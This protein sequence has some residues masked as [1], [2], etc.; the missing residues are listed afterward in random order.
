[1][2]TINTDLGSN[3]E[4]LLQANELCMHKAIGEVAAERL[5]A[6]IRYHLESGG[7]R[8]RAKIALNAGIAL[9]LH[10]DICLALATSCELIHNAS[11]LHDDIQ[12]G[13]EMRRGRES[14]WF[15]YDVN[16]A[17]CAGTLML[18]AA[19]RA[20]SQVP[21]YA[22]QLLAH[23]YQRTSDLISGQTI[24]LTSQ[25]QH[26]DVQTYLNI[27]KGKSGS[28]LALPFELVMISANQTAAIPT[29]KAAGESFAVAYQIAD[30]ISD[31]QGDLS[32]HQNNIIK[33]LHD[34]GLDRPHALAKANQLA[35]D[36]LNLAINYASQ[37]PANSGACF[38]PLCEKLALTI[39]APTQF[40]CERV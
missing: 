21:V 26:F 19:Y 12:D 28:L 16:S 30:D 29:A 17:L 36:H 24:D 1:M 13:D 27:A 3:L 8:L 7:A 23:L 20:I 18:S 14:A 2:R 40:S 6:V 32:Q 11:L 34:K 22:P 33:V 4:S 38:I 15:K 31:L 9:N 37:L 35:H 10:T 39:G 5:A 25:T